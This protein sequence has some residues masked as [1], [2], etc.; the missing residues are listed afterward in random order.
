MVNDR[1]QWMKSLHNGRIFD[2]DKKDIQ[3]AV[4][5][6]P[7]IHPPLP[8]QLQELIIK[9]GKSYKF[10]KNQKLISI[11]R[12]IDHLAIVTEGVTARNFGSPI[13]TPNGAAISPVG[14][15]AFGNLNFFTGRAAIGHYFALTKAKISTIDKAVLLSLL[16][17][18]PDQYSLFQRHLECCTLSD[19][20]AFSL[21]AS[22][23]VEMR[24]KC[25]VIAWAI[26]YAEVFYEN[27]QMWLRMPIPLTRILRA[28][29]VN[30]SSVSIDK[31]LKKWAE[32]GVWLRDGSFCTCLVDFF[33]EGYR[34]M[35]DVEESCEFDYPSTL[36]ELFSH[37]PLLS[38]Y[39]H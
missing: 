28:L 17:D 10:D 38:A 26:E 1:S 5:I 39:G 3:H 34:W 23:S 22:A 27:G 4:P 14:H 29:V 30:T 19:R 18:D 37:L 21:Y 20:L 12:K 2:I 7:W 25:F 32:D 6:V 15:I 33:E 16:K 11:D 35:R 13:F 8:L 36:K 24:M 31:W 9:N